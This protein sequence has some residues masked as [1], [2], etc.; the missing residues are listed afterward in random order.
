MR[1][2]SVGNPRPYNREFRCR[3][4]SHRCLGTQ[5]SEFQIGTWRIGRDCALRSSGYSGDG[6]LA[7]CSRKMVLGNCHLAGFLT[8]PASI[9]WSVSVARRGNSIGIA[10]AGLRSWL[11][12]PRTDFSPAARTCTPA[13]ELHGICVAAGCKYQP[14]SP[15]ASAWRSRANAPPL[16]GS[17]SNASS[18]SAQTSWETRTRFRQGQREPK[19][20]RKVDVSPRRQ[21]LRTSSGTV[22]GDF[23]L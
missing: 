8:V 23:T 17:R 13:E 20:R 4:T 18:R 10:R 21:F 3:R 2:K 19:P 9:T 14:A 1:T 7:L 22:V 6:G 11:L 12:Y 15:Q 5:S 16:G